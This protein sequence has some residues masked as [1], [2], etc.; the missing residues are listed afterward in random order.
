MEPDSDESR[1][2][3]ITGKIMV[4]AIIILFLVV[5]FVLFLHLY[6]KWFWWSV[7]EPTPQSSSRRRRRF[8]FAPGQDTAHPLRATKGL[9]PT[10]LASLPVLIYSQ[11]E[12]KEGLECAVCL[13]EVVEGEKARLLPKCNH[14]FHVECVDMWFKSH[15]T[16]PLCRN[17]VVAVEGEN[18]SSAMSGDE[19]NIG[20]I[21]SPH[22][23]GLASGYSTDSPT[24]PTNVLFW[25]NH[26]GQVSSGGA[27]LEE[28][29]SASALASASSAAF[30]SSSMASGSGR[31]EGMLVINVPMNANENFP[32]EESKSPM[33]TRLRSLKRRLSREK[34]MV[35][36][37]SGT[38]GS[39]DV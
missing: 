5:V 8:V 29:S 38:N 24:F 37:G 23:D 34:R 6:A 12:F 22:D 35:P 32:E 27:N 26:Q 14:G 36:S 7:E 16:C 25:G 13:C 21:Q 10:I 17:S 33:P 3:A 28:G 19:V 20:H 39:I 31:Q 11:E 2:V 30:A 1:A 4:I 15:S 18:P 9:D